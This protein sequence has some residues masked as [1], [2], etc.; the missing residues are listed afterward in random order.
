VAT[1]SNCLVRHEYPIDRHNATI[2]AAS[3]AL[4]TSCLI[5]ITACSILAD[6]EDLLCG[7]VGFNNSILALRSSCLRGVGSHGRQLITLASM[8]WHVMRLPRKDLR[9]SSCHS[10]LSPFPLQIWS[11]APFFVTPRIKAVAALLTEI[12]LNRSRI[13]DIVLIC[14]K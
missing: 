10:W 6:I 7:S 13:E 12:G 9:L 1:G 5:C 8:C 3:K 14:F 4:L 11:L 2:A